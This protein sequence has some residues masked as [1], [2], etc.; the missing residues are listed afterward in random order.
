EAVAGGRIPDREQLLARYPEFATEL[1]E[2]LQGRQQ[3]DGLATPLRQAVAAPTP[4]WGDS[5]SADEPL[6]GRSFGDYELLE[7]VGRGG[8]GVVYKARQK[9][10]NRMVALKMIRAGRL[11]DADEARRFRN[12]AE[13]VARLDHPNIVPIHE[14]G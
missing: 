5:H 3:L 1:A 12:E 13:M 10:L 4:A 2:Y 8:M 6:P 7:E 14:V 11:G 9:R